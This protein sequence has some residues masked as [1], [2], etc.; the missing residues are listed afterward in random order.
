[1]RYI[2]GILAMGKEKE[3]DRIKYWRV[4]PTTFAR[5]IFCLDEA[6]ISSKKL[7]RKDFQRA[8]LLK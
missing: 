4:G 1:M 7:D 6:R 8:T 2:N 5:Y 3:R